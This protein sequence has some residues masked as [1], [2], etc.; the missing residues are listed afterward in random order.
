[1]DDQMTLGQLIDALR[2][3]DKSLGVRFE[4]CGMVPCYL[5]SYR[6]FYDQLAFDY[7]PPDEEQERG[8]FLTVGDLLAHCEQVVG[9]VF[10]GYKGGNYTMGLDTPLWVDKWGR[11]TSTAVVGTVVCDCWLLI[12]TARVSL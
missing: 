2:K 4:F 3:A 12:K 8:G 10:V 9:K 1:M 7:R 11:C 5:K 6:G